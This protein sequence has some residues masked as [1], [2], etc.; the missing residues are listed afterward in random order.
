MTETVGFIISR[1]KKVIKSVN[2]DAFI[3]DRFIYSLVLKHAAWIL[4][5]EDSMMKILRFTSSFQSLDYVELIEVDTIEANCTGLSTG[6][7]IKRTKEKVP[8]M[9]QGYWGPIIRSISSI[10]GSD[11]LTSTTPEAYLKISSSKNYKYNKTKYYW[12]LN[13]YIYFPDIPWDAVKIIGMFEEDISF[14][15]CDPKDSCVAKQDR[16]FNVPGYLHAEIESHVLK[17][18]LGFMLQIPGDP[19]HDKQNPQR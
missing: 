15:K 10:D 17:E 16:S 9:L 2:Q 14:Y 4:R 12:F 13:G 1:I 6:C 18:D 3:T 8:G 11:D 5:R 7:V 19:T